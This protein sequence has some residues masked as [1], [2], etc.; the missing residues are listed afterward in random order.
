MDKSCESGTS[1]SPFRWVTGTSAHPPHRRETAIE[2]RSNVEEIDFFNKM[3]ETVL[4]FMPSA[5]FF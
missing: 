2:K 3:T 5:S 1:R 4:E